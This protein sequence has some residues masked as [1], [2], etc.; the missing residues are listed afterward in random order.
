MLRLTGGLAA[1]RD[2]ASP[3]L[4]LYDGPARVELSGATVANWVSKTANLLVDGHDRPDRVGLLL[5][6][7][8]QLPCFLLGAAAAGCAV[9]V[10]SMPA[11]L[12]GCSLAF[13]DLEHA[14]R[15]LDAG[16]EDVL[17]A[18]GHPLGARLPAVPA[19]CL[20]AAVE[21]PA[22]GDRYSGPDAGPP[23][24]LLDG[25]PFDAPGLGLG[26]DDR[27][28][29]TLAPTTPRGL[30]VLLAALRA[31]SS[32]VLLADGDAAA[33]AGAERVTA[34]AGTAVPG[35]REL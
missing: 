29:T 35:L 7:H 8:W 27:V 14:D 1:D 6:L 21:V 17:V 19:L 9:V 4:T 11:S 5:P 23:M 22:Y 10:A 34:V 20:D 13:V 25:E 18:S 15:A 30:G 28:L 32:L 33:V 2:P 12:Q 24:V 3:L 31:G 16:V 26:P